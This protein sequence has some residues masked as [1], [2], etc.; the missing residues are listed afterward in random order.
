MTQKRLIVCDL[1][2]T[3]YDW[4]SYFVPS[5]YAM[6]DKAVE[7]LG[8]DR[9]T[10]LDEFRE[11]HRRYHD[12]EHPFSLLETPSVKSRFPNAVR[13]DLA[14]YMDPAFHAFNSTR[15]RSLVVHDGVHETLAALSSNGV[16]IVAHTESR[17]YS[18]LDRLR[19]LD[20]INYFSRVYCRARSDSEHPDPE[21]A[22]NWLAK[23]PMSK[24]TELGSHQMK[25]NR[26]VLFD[27][28]TREGVSVSDAAYVGDSIA[29]DV[30]MAKDAGV[31]AIWA[32]YGATHDRSDY[33]ALVRVSHWTAQDVEFE[34]SLN[35][36][37]KDVAPDFV[38]NDGF[39]QVAV[40]LGFTLPELEASA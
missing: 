16:S 38:A 17:L 1:D 32:K 39:W 9:E 12:S 26:D 36:R 25:P 23:F 21:V 24:V 37:A 7:L 18:A 29:K 10:L 27:I 2:N 8:C 5:F 40:A 4:V 3:L 31:F 34:K 19:R 13:S 28:C 20:L 33:E 14:E 22:R 30:M 11:V 15:N 35:A 6:A